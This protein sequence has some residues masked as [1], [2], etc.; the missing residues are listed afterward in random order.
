MYVADVT[1]VSIS[2]AF[3]DSL[4][5]TLN[6]LIDF[7]FSDHPIILVV[8]ESGSIP[9]DLAS[10]LCNLKIICG[11]DTGIYNAMNLG[12]Q[13]AGAEGYVWFLNAG[14]RAHVH[15]EILREYLGRQDV[16]Y[17]TAETPK[18]KRLNSPIGSSVGMPVCHQSILVSLDFLER[19]NIVYDER[20][21]IV[22]DWDWFLSITE[23]TN[24][25]RELALSIT[26]I[27]KPGLSSIMGRKLICEKCVVRK[28]HNLNRTFIVFDLGKALKRNIRRLIANWA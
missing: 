14:D 7:G 18:G 1:I 22:A 8:S 27:E 28:R 12:L 6:S 3:D 25:I 11:Q 26:K 10:R 13:G 5:D 20:L 23:S 21:S 16:I 24:N 17:G 2:K 9:Q 19:K 4:F 15:A